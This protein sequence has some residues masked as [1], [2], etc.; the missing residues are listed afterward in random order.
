MEK[1]IGDDPG[2]RRAATRAE[3]AAPGHLL[4]LRTIAGDARRN[5]SF[6]RC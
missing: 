1:S 3:S 2:R 6:C 4:I 5:L